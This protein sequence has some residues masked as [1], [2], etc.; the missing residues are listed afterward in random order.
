[1]ASPTLRTDQSLRIYKHGQRLDILSVSEVTIFALTKTQHPWFEHTDHT[2]EV[3]LFAET[4]A[5]TSDVVA[6]HGLTVAAWNLIGQAHPA[7]WST[8][9]HQARQVAL[10]FHRILTAVLVVLAA[11]SGFMSRISAIPQGCSL[12]S[13]PAGTA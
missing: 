8:W 5:A 9:T 3:Y 12:P 7:A 11:P 4:A 6:T 10:A 2:N 13:H 1:M